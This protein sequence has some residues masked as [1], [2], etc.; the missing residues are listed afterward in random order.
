MYA[1]F[2]A[3]ILLHLLAVWYVWHL[4]FKLQDRTVKELSKPGA[5]AQGLDTQKNLAEEAVT[6]H[7]R[8]TGHS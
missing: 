5:V 6:I 2:H 4:I 8:A 3:I 7:S 1:A